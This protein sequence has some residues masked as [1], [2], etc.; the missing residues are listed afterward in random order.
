MY[1]VIFVTPN[2]SGEGKDECNGTLQLATI[3]KNQGVSCNIIQFFRI[4]DVKHFDDF[5]RNFENQIE[6]MSPKIVSFYCRCDTYHIMLRLAQRIKMRWENIYTVLGGPQSDITSEDTIRLIPWVDYVCCGEGETTIHPFFSSLL[7]NEPDLSVPGL[8]YRDNGTVVKNPRPELITN[9][10]EL[11]MLDYSMFHFDAEPKANQSIDVGR[12]CPF[13]CTF[14]TTNSFW[15]RTFRL[16]S[17]QRIFEE[18]KHLHDVYG[19]TQF[20]FSHDMFTLKRDKVKETCEL[21][22]NSNLNI[23]WGCS[24]RLDCIDEELIDIMAESGLT[25]IYLGIE[26]GSPR[27]QKLINKNLKLENALRI[28]K[29]LR[30]KDIGVI[31]SFIYGFPEENEEDL[32][33]TISLMLQLMHL[34]KVQIQTHLCTFLEGTELS[35]K[36]GAELTPLDYYSDVTGEFAIE[37]CKDLIKGY[38]QLFQHMLEYKTELRTKLRYFSQFMNVWKFLEPVYYYISKKYPENRLID[39]YYD[40]VEANK[41]I[42]SNLDEAPEYKIGIWLGTRDRFIERFADDE[43]YDIMQDYLRY[44][45]IENSQEV[46]N[47]ETVTDMFCFAP[48]DLRKKSIGEIKRCMA[49]VTWSKNERSIACFPIE[50]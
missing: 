40:F 1:D 12:G 30:S 15:G 14:C 22:R 43:N 5:L 24:A 7:K 8:V 4:G 21:L 36:Y 2:M 32:S 11:P 38:P 20:G 29:Y 16:K 44:K 35:K 27:M 17:P 34:G 49:M 19:K 6:E 41:E 9:L 28:V 45:T 42:L 26:T 23:E 18:I 37:E 47:G 33:Q 10:D 3:L 13:N 39:M 48:G 31:T 50:D 46:R 25:R